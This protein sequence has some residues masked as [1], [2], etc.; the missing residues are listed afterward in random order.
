M[1]SQQLMMNHLGIALA[2]DSTVTLG[3][4]GRT[5]PS[6]NKIFSLSGR[7]PVAF[8][9]S[10]AANFIPAGISWERVIGLYREYRRDEELPRLVDYISDFKKFITT[11]EALCVS[12]VNDIAIQSDLITKF[13]NTIK[14]AAEK[15]KI[16]RA[17]GFSGEEMWKETDLTNY[18]DEAISKRIED[19]LFQVR[20]QTKE[21]N[22]GKDSDAWHNHQYK[23]KKRHFNNIQTASEEFVKRH[24]CPELYENMCEIFLYHLSCFEQEFNWRSKSKIVICG[25]GKLEMKPTMCS[26]EV[27]CD[28]GNGPFSPLTRYYIRNRR[29][30]SDNGAWIQEENP[31][32]PSEYLWSTIGFTSGFAQK[33]NMETLLSGIHPNTRSS[34]GRYLAPQIVKEL[35]PM[36][37]EMVSSVPGVGKATLEKISARM[38]EGTGELYEKTDEIVKAALFDEWGYHRRRFQKVTASVPLEELSKFVEILVS[39]EA[40]VSHYLHDVRS[41]GGPIDVATISKED[42]FIWIKSKQLHE[43]KLNPRLDTVER[44]SANLI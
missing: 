11:H 19:I 33:D 3:D 32:D 16:V 7:Q 24:E 23:V 20:T 39:L 37:T 6:V 18:F 27:G 12:E 41:V 42:G 21:R 22:E 34:L 9:I 35:S 13:T 2:S 29:S 36:I 26:F 44:N 15:E 4:S 14:P 10:N 31:N 38:N 40:Q 5:Y 43:S 30:Y 25:F 8:M 1:T 17:T 28:I